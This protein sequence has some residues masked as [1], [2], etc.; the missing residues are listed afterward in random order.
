MDRDKKKRKIE[1]IGRINFLDGKEKLRFEI[2]GL[3]LWRSRINA[4]EGGRNTCLS[5]TEQRFAIKLP[6][7]S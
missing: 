1:K 4:R 5:A 7:G 6:R 3:G 2:D